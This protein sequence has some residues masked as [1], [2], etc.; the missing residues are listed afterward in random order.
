M[1]V[2][3]WTPF[4]PSAP[5]KSIMQWYDF[6]GWRCTRDRNATQTFSTNALLQLS[7]YKWITTFKNGCN[8]CDWWRVIRASVQIHH[9]G[10][11]WTSLCNDSVWSVGDCQWRGTS[12]AHQSWF[13][14]GIIKGDL[15]SIKIVREGFQKN[16]QESPSAIICQSAK[17][18]WI[19][20]VMK[21]TLSWHALALGKRYGSSITFQNINAREENGNIQHCQSERSSKLNH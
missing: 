2:E 6:C 12:S 11:H 21:V 5:K 19:S 18:Y 20:V 8:K 9:R 17:A 15:N 3:A 4:F 16:S 1:Q 10:K 7:V 13:C 14:T